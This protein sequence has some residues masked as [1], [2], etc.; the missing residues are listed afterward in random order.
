M[1]IALIQFDS[2]WGDPRQNL[3]KAIALTNQL[4][5]DTD[6]VVFPETFTS[7][8]HPEPHK[9]D[10]IGPE[11]IQ[12]SLSSGIKSKN[13][14][15]MASVACSENG[16]FYNRLFL[17]DQNG[18]Q[19]YDKVHLFGPGR[20]KEAFTPGSGPEIF[21]FRGISI[22]P[23]ICYDLRF[24]Y[25]SFDSSS[26][27]LII[28]CANWPE[29]RISHWNQLLAARAIENQ[30]YVI[31]VNRLGTDGLGLRYPGHSKV[32]GFDGSLLL[33]A[34][35]ETVTYVQLQFQDQIYYRKTLPFSPD[36]LENALPHWT[37]D[38]S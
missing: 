25:M 12:H 32:F 20:E 4:E 10:L 1:K 33:D 30:T 34:G 13:L 2:L 18:L 24:P 37:R 6:L 35:A 21:S 27:D 23:L 22:R 29:A 28:Y 7:G 36:R 26:C 31:G 3:E 15:V 5:P 16:G 38:Q 17:K 14:A 19:T 9:L 8:F 11:E